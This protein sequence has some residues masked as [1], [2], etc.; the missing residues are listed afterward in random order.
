MSPMKRHISWEAGVLVLTVLV[1]LVSACQMPSFLQSELPE[2]GPAVAVSQGAALR[3]IEKLRSAGEQ[4]AQSQRVSLSVTQEEVTSFLSIGSQLSEQLEAMQ[5]QS[6]AQLE[7][8]QDSP[9]LA[10][11]EGL[12]DWIGLLRGGEGVPNLSL[13][14]L[15]LSIQ[16][17]QVRFRGNGQMF[18]SGYAQA[19]GQRQGLRLVLAPRAAGGELV[20]DFVEGTL[21]PI[22]V[23]ELIIDQIGL[24]LAKLILAGQDFVEISQIRVEEGR[25]TVSG[26][27]R[28]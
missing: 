2:D 22:P 18:I 24:V 7:Q 27:Y 26:A 23:P 13:S 16:E 15:G 19:L 5:I 4:A 9:E 1:L 8:L 20:L 14:E 28:Q 21:G 17:P 11:F 12:E 3:F 25:L 6:M 10:Q